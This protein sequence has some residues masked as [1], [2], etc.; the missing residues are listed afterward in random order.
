MIPKMVII[1]K[2]GEMKPFIL[3]LMMTGINT[4]K[5]VD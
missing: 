2:F 1:P 5:L 4:P 3:S